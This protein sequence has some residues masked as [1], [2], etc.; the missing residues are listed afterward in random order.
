VTPVAAALLLAFS[1]AACEDPPAGPG[2]A[3]VTPP[4]TP[5]APADP[6]R[7]G[8]TAPAAKTGPKN[9]AEAQAII[10][11]DRKK[12]DAEAHRL[13]DRF[14]D[15]LYDPMRDGGLRTAA[16]TAE[17]EVDGR[18]GSFRFAFDG[19]KK[20]AEQVTVEPVRTDEGLHPDAKGQ[21][22]RFVVLATRGPYAAV[23]SYAPPVQLTTTR[24]EDGA[25]IVV[26]PPF[27]SAAGVSY[28]LDK[29]GLV[30]LSG[31]SDGENVTRTVFQWVERAGRHQLVRAK[32]DGG[33]AVTSYEYADDR[34]FSLL[35]EASIVE[36][37]HECVAKLAWTEVVKE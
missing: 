28:R 35:R 18:K 23:I 4:V 11:E 7:E 1:L 19:S 8:T 9:Q 20:D 36:G 34:G 29:K 17:I 22:L 21:V 5:A 24:G 6:P 37:V 25:D 30:A 10:D 27:K 15:L 26:A 3:T 32:E 2:P 33:K 13:L 16:G 12:R 14:R 31:Q